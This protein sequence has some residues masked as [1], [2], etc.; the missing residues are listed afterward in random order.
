MMMQRLIGVAFVAMGLGCFVLAPVNTVTCERREDSVDCTLAARVAGIVA[1]QEVQA[2]GLVAVRIDTTTSTHKDTRQP[3]D[4]NAPGYHL[5][6]VGRDGEQR[7]RS[8]SSRDPARVESLADPIQRVLAGERSARARQGADAPGVIFGAVFTIFGLLALVPTWIHTSPSTPRQ[9]ALAAPAP[10]PARPARHWT[11]TAASVIALAGIVIGLACAQWGFADLRYGRL[12]EDP[13]RRSRF[14]AEE[15]CETC[16]G[17]LLVSHLREIGFAELAF[18]GFLAV[19]SAFLL[20]GRP[21]ARKALMAGLAML[22]AYI[23]VVQVFRD[24]V[25]HAT[26]WTG[27]MLGGGPW[28]PPGAADLYAAVVPMVAAVVVLAQRD[29]RD[30]LAPPGVGVPGPGVRQ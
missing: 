29:L 2:R 6:L 21:W 22:T 18:G 24:V 7:P 4:V 9:P 16:L 1:I 28:T 14:P 3:G 26:H 11:R 25:G 5:V 12:L 10:S 17:D 30:A 27:L 19:S 8:F 15:D 23:L 20:L 13:D